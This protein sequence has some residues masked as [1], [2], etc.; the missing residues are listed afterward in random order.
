MLKTLFMQKAL[1]IFSFLFFLVSFLSLLR[2][3]QLN[4]YPD[5]SQYFRGA[6]TIAQGIN[7]YVVAN[8]SLTPTVYP[9]F[10]LFL[11]SPL[12]LLSF[13]WAEK[14]WTVFSIIALFL[15]VY[16]VFRIYKKNIISSLGFVVLGLVCLS[17]PVKFTLGMGQIN[18]VVLLLF[19]LSI[20]FLEKKKESLSG[21]FQSIALAIKFYPLF[22]PLYFL[23]KRKWKVLIVTVFAFAVF[24]VLAFLINPK[25]NNYFYTNIFPTFFNNWKTAYYNQALSGFIGRSISDYKVANLIRFCASAFF[26]LISFAVIIKSLTKE[27]LQNMQLGLLISLNLIVSSFSWQ[28]HFVLMIF[29]FLVTLFYV[30]KIKKNWKFLL[31]IFIS[32]LL[33]SFN[34]KNPND[35]PILLQSHVFYGA[36]L[37]WILQIYLIWKD[38]HRLELHFPLTSKR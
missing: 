16:L 36:V 26:V 33:I 4:L 24:Y 32:Y 25:I 3:L 35:V 9:P 18:N 19:V 11:L 22:F 34:L 29:P 20:Y 8:G 38:S 13:F 15:S 1:K 37:L 12:G 10:V 27:K 5:F 14:L 30:Q 28:H 31:T 17:F 6:K 23:F 21:F 7:P 2:V